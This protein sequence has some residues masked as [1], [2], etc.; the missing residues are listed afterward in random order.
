M[1]ADAKTFVGFAAPLLIVYMTY[2]SIS[3]EV[4]G[5]RS[6]DLK[7]ISQV[8]ISVI[9]PLPSKEGEVRNPFV[10]DGHSD[11]AFVAG[12][13]GA[14]GDGEDNSELRLDG[15]VLAGN[16][17]FAIINGVRVMEGDFFRGLKLEKV[18]V[19]QVRMT[20]GKQ[21]RILPL[22]IA[23]SDSIRPMEVAVSTHSRDSK[24]KPDSK[25]S[26]PGPGTAGRAESKTASASPSRAKH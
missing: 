18:E 10:P 3:A 23:K 26:A 1:D 4:A 7:P 16:M 19:S 17:R 2:A 8:Q 6:T 22:S 11:Y 25:Q 15:T 12:G 21:E 24:S 14:K 9:P 13:S 5:G 20:G